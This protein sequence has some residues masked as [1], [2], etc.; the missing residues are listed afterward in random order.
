M[1]SCCRFRRNGSPSTGALQYFECVGDD[2]AAK[3]VTAT[4]RKA[5]RAKPSETVIFA[6]IVF[7]SKAHRNAVNRK[8]FR[9]PDIAQM[10]EAM[11]FDM[12]RMAYAGFKAIVEA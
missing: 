1:G 2:L 4:F 11:P 12:R 8:V 3:G 7:K 10:V 9:D 6:F 5:S